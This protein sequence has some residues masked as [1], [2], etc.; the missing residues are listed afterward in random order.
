MTKKYI[1]I[2]LLIVSFSFI[3][4]GCWDSEDIQNKDIITATIVDYKNGKFI[5][6]NE[7]A[8]IKG[9]RKEKQGTFS[10]LKSEG[11]TITSAR[12]NV[13]RRNDHPIFLGAIRAIIFTKDMAEYGIEPYMNRVR[14]LQDS[15]KTM[16]IAITFN[17]PEMIMNS[18]SH[19]G[20]ST[21][22]TIENELKGLERNN[23][24][25]RVTGEDILQS[26][27]VKNVGFAVPSIKYDEGDII[28]NGYSIFKNGKIIGF[29]PAEQRKGLVYL[30]AKKSRSSYEVVEKDNKFIID[31]TMKKRKIKPTFENG[32]LKLKINMDFR[33]EITYMENLAPISDEIKNKIEKSLTTMI[34]NDVQKTIAISQNEFKCDYFYFYKYFRTHYR[35][36]FENINWNEVYSKAYIDININAQIKPKGMFEINP[37]KQ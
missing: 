26:L 20:V 28:F 33:G 22:F 32:K 30:V 19:N 13:D 8:N 18:H 31:T 4:T 27:T 37:K 7:I 35:K 14:S 16:D 11:N 10:I 21:A 29:I 6:W 2:M 1:K 25:F 36:E 3:F 9:S 17:D 24:I 34:K 23:S 12:D 5:F 15:R